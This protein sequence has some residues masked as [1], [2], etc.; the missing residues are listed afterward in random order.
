[1]EPLVRDM[2]TQDP[3]SRPTMD[4]VVARFETICKSL[5]SW[6]LRSRVVPRDETIEIPFR[7]VPHWLRRIRYIIMRK[8]AVPSPTK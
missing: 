6:R 2:M 5:S 7:A 1:M 8:P 4:E 3:N